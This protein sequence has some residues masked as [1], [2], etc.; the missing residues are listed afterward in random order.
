MRKKTRAKLKRKDRW[1][2]LILL[3]PLNMVAQFDDSHG[4]LGRGGSRDDT[5]IFNSIMNRG[6]GATSGGLF[7]Q[8]F[9]FTQDYLDNQDFG[10]TQGGITNQTFEE[11]TPL[12]SGLFILLAAGA[13]YASLKTKKRKSNR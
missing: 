2:L 10:S 7:N 3:L 9:G 1:L 6:F 13:G 11:E 4:L 5:G 12:G 8:G